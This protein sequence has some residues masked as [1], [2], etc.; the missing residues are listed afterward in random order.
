MSISVVT[1]YEP[2]W[3]SGKVSRR[4]SARFR[5]GSPLSSKGCGLW[6]LSSGHYLV[7]LSLTIKETLKWLLSLPICKCRSHFGGDRQCSDRYIISLF[8]HLRP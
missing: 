1:E 5:F 8:P 7:T 6:T 2:V 4:A 3:P